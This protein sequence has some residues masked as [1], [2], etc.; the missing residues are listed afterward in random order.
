MVIVIEVGFART[1]ARD[2]VKVGFVKTMARCLVVSPRAEFLEKRFCVS[3][4]GSFLVSRVGSIL[5]KE[6]R[7]RM[8]SESD[9]DGQILISMIMTSRVSNS[10]WFRSFF[11]LVN[12]WL[13]ACALAMGGC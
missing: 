13:R 7:A 8:D 1:V 4:V 10:S 12:P 11:K 5:R 3:R 9:R 6:I 2:I